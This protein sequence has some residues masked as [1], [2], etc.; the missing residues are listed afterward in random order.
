MFKALGRAPNIEY[1]DMPETIRGQY[2][3]FTQSSIE[4]LR[5]AGYNAG[6]T[7]LDKAVG[8]YVTGYLDRPTG[9]AD[10]LCSMFDKH[11]LTALADQTVLCIGDLMLDEFVYGRSTRISPE[12]PTPVIAVKRTRGH[13]RRRRQCRAQSGRARRALHFRRRGRRRRCRHAL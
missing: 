7:P 3:Y 12:A 4:N 6:F 11:A 13:G 8:Q 2:Q 5:R 1:I 10:R 9:T